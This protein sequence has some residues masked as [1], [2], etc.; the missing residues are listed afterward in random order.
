MERVADWIFTIVDRLGALGVGLLIF[1][2]NVIPPSGT[3]V[4]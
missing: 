3:F 1:L 2:E 4:R